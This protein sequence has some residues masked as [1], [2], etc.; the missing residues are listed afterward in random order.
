MEWPNSNELGRHINE[1]PCPRSPD[2][3]WVFI[4]EVHF[5]SEIFLKFN[6]LNL[7]GRKNHRVTKIIDQI[8]NLRLDHSCK[9]IRYNTVL[10]LKP[11]GL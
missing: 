8:L 7:K 6:I 2:Y 11:R 1:D 10:S 3:T 5:H 4:L 9:I